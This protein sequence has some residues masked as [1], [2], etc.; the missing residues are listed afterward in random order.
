MHVMALSIAVIV[1][2]KHEDWRDVSKFSFPMLCFNLQEPLLFGM[3]VV[4]N[5]VFLLPFVLA[6]MANALIGWIAISWDI[7]PIFKY[8]IPMG[9]PP[10]FSGMMSTGSVMGGILQLVWLITDIFIYAPFVI[11]SN[12]AEPEELVP[13]EDEDQ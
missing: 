3:P 2:S 8:A 12:M 4:L 1:F 9:M 10:F 6:P 13:K 11:V 5:A 7:V